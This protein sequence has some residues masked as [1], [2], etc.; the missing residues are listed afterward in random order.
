MYIATHLQY[1]V[2]DKNSKYRCR[3]FYTRHYAPPN[4]TQDNG[5]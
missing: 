3:V 2:F 4:T 5:Q 1:L